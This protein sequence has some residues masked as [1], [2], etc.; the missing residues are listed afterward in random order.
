MVMDIGIRKGGFWNF[1]Q[2]WTESNLKK[3][4]KDIKA[5][6]CEECITQSK[7]LVYDFEI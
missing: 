4:V 3:F 5:L 1:R 7:L 6:P 2:L